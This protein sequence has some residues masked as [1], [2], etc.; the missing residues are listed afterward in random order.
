M[1]GI[2]STEDPF[3]RKPEGIG[4]YHYYDPVE[5]RKSKVVALPA[6]NEEE[7]TRMIE[8]TEAYRRQF[9]YH[10]WIPQ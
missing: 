4:K 8:Q 7:M 9:K 10:E 2:K 6:E 1:F 3:G 5:D